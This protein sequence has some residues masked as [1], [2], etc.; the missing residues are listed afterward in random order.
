MPFIGEIAALTAAFFWGSTTFLFNF[1][2]KKI[3]AFPINVL[4][5]FFACI[6]L[7]LTLYIQ[8]GYFYPVSAPHHASFWLGISGVIGLAI[9]DGA[10]FFS[11]LCIGPR[12][13]TLILA[14][15]PPFTTV[16]AWLFL[17]ETLSI[18]ALLGI[19]LTLT[20]IVWVVSE[21]QPRLNFPKNKT[22]GILYGIIAALGQGL[23]VIFA[24]IGLESNI[25]TM[26]ATLL[27][28]MPASAALWLMALFI[29]QAKPAVLAFKNKHVIGAIVLGTIFG[30]F[31]GVWLSIVAVKYTAAGIASTLLS[32]VPV[33]IIPLEIIF[34]R[35]IPSPRAII[36]TVLAIVGVALIFMR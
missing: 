18:Y 17:G 14:L 19:T 28:M 22:A 15:A 13:A 20:A 7:G 5:V 8:E 27:R 4:R 11:I 25:D 36:G 33:L 23:G 26:S 10:L 3:G 29:K 2:G 6:L 1:A 24:K 16:I 31:L 30:P 34:F 21:R 32:T 9:G 35:R 12:L